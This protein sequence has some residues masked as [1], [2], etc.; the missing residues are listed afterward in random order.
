MRDEKLIVLIFEDD[1]YIG[2]SIEWVN[3]CIFF[4]ALL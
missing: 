3:I 1:A 2:F 4:I